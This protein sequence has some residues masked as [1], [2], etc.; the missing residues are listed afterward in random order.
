M[1]SAARKA[2]TSRH[3]EA[4]MPATSPVP[5]TSEAP[6]RRP[7][8]RARRRRPALASV[9]PATGET[10]RTF[11]TLTAG[12]LDE[13]I[14]RSARAFSAYRATPLTE[15][16]RTMRRAA[17]ILDEERRAFARLITT[18]MGK[19]I[20]AAAQEVAKCALAC[21]YYAEHAGRL[22]ADE[23]VEVEAGRA[24]IR[25]QPLGPVLAVMPWNFPFWQVFR[26]AA[27]ALMAGN[28]ALLKHAGNVPQCGL[29]IEHVFASAGF[30]EGVFTTLLIGADQVARVLDD[31][32]VVAATVT[33]SEGAGSAVAGHAGARIK[34]TVLELGGSDPFIVLSGTRLEETV[35]AAV[36]ARVVN[37]GQ[38]CIAAKRFIVVEAVA[39]EF[40]GRFV[41]AMA[42]LTVGDPLDPSTEV[43]PLATAQIRD[44]LDEQVRR[45][46]EAGARVLT[47]GKR[48]DRPGWYYAPTVL[49]DIPEGCP[50]HREELFGPVAALFRA[51]D[52][53]E[54]LAIAND[55]TF[56]LGASV[57]THDDA[58]RERFVDG[59]ESGMV[60]VNGIVVSDPRL[61]F[62]GVKRSGYG[63]ELGALGLR[64]FVNVKTVRV[65]A[66]A[67]EAATPIT[68]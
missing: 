7:P 56:G 68:E 51:R 11:E 48:L 37:S 16:A 36:S 25:Y 9:N 24:F 62:G 32:R 59:L 57:W 41:E 61:P 17:D 15:R 46:V 49:T 53:E 63:R 58:E 10:I 38:S 23:P 54:A 65:A 52:A 5:G 43:G 66:G 21:R 19:P 60:F 22:L 27:P 13:R 45:S 12:E 14:A 26:F 64:E 44:G 39:E 31:E 42:R 4:P 33:G 3:G 35:A 29:A 30:D 20:D 40:Q 34:K 55:T 47:G 1:H 2:S 50:A 67:P 6:P 18:E 8:G 28:V